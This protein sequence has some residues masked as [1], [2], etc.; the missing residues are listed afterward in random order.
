M[1]YE[2]EPAALRER[3]IFKTTFEYKL[4]GS[5]LLT[6]GFGKRTVCISPRGTA[7]VDSKPKNPTAA[8]TEHLA[9]R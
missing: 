5:H 9:A 7:S 1:S 6:P 2:S 8:P 4:C 3:D